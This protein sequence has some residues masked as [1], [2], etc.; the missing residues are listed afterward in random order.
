MVSPLPLAAR[1]DP[2]EA[3]PTEADET[4]EMAL[5]GVTYQIDLSDKNAEAL[6][7]TFAP[8]IAAARRTGGR[9]SVGAVR[10]MRPDRVDRLHELHPLARHRRR[11]G[12]L[13]SLPDPQ[14]DRRRRHTG[15]D[16]QPRRPAPP[17]S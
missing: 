6:R 7:S 5:G 3:T 1:Q 14:R 16:R 15:P 13:P 4:V 11:P 12:D 2:P 10:S 17:R 8:Y 9:R